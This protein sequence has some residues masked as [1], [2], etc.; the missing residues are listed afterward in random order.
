MNNFIFS[1]QQKEIFNNQDKLIKELYNKINCLEKEISLKEQQYNK[2]NESFINLNEQ[3][4]TI[5]KTLLQT[6]DKINT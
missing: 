3:L 2:L 5:N 6:K 1:S 4:K